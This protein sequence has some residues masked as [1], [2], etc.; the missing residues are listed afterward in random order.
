MQSG[1]VVGGDEVKKEVFFM[2][3]ACLY[4]DGSD[5]GGRQIA[6]GRIKRE[7]WLEPWP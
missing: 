1:A 5:L 4:A 2:I 3:T 7:D 6:D